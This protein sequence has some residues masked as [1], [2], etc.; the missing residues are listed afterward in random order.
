MS[1]AA[2]VVPTGRLSD[3]SL[4]ASAAAPPPVEVWLLG[5]TTPHQYVVYATIN[6]TN[7][8]EKLTITTINTM[9]TN[10]LR[11]FKEPRATVDYIRFPEDNMIEV[12]LYIPSIHPIADTLLRDRFTEALTTTIVTP[13]AAVAAVPL[14][15]SFTVGVYSRLFSPD[16]YVVYATIR[17]EKLLA[18]MTPTLCD[19]IVKHVVDAASDEL[20][21]VIPQKILP[22]VKGSEILEVH[23]YA[24]SPEAMTNPASDVLKQKFIQ[25]LTVAEPAPAMGTTY[26]MEGNRRSARLAATKTSVSSPPPP[27]K[28]QIPLADRPAGASAPPTETATAAETKPSVG[29]LPSYAPAGCTDPLPKA[30][31]NL[32]ATLRGPTGCLFITQKGTQCKRKP[33]AHDCVCDQHA[34]MGKRPRGA[35]LPCPPGHTLYPEPIKMSKNL[36]ELALECVEEII[37]TLT[38]EDRRVQVRFRDDDTIPDMTIFIDHIN[39]ANPTMTHDLVRKYSHPSHTMLEKIADLS[40]RCSR[41]LACWRNKT[42]GQDGAVKHILLIA[43]ELKPLLSYDG[44]DCV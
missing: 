40:A 36:R 27:V 4:S 9:V 38:T 43:K 5:H 29:A 31:Q 33:A 30:G 44:Y 17:D 12:T 41:T 24:S 15:V 18:R 3:D 22:P 13:S 19:S 8:L 42:M 16:N 23:M 6:D 1:A 35:P 34:D 10:I 26:T 21:V 39:H 2:S 11:S 25:A 37:T 28:R 32:S 20:P 7:I 14:R